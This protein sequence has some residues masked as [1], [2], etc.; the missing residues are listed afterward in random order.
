MALALALTLVIAFFG[1]RYYASQ[2]AKVARQEMLQ[3]HRLVQ[4][5]VQAARLDWENEHDFYGY[6]TRGGG[7]ETAADS[8]PGKSAA[9]TA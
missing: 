9:T 6:R 2:R 4:D 8:I 5:I 7:R 3:M 1:H